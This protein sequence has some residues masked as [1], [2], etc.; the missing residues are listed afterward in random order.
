MVV[1]VSPTDVDVVDVASPNDVEVVVDTSDDDVDTSSTNDGLLS[2]E[3][4]LDEAHAAPPD[5]TTATVT[6][7][8]FQRRLRAI[9]RPF[10]PSR[11]FAI[12]A[13]SG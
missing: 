10:P 2:D 13:Q 12:G 3:A 6:S 1:V 8:T 11:S 4:P 5:N 9:I 7:V